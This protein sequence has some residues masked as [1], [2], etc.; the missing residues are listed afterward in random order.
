[1][2]RYGSWRTDLL[3]CDGN[4]AL[5]VEAKRRLQIGVR[6]IGTAQAGT[7]IRTAGT[8]SQCAPP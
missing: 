8:S 1:M 7:V 6:Y 5:L 4:T 2:L 3:C